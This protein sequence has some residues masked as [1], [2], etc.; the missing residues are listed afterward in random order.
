[1]IARFANDDTDDKHN[2]SLVPMDRKL[3]FPKQRK[4]PNQRMHQ[5]G[6]SDPF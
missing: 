6:F 1:M 4:T 5:T 3:K 2:V